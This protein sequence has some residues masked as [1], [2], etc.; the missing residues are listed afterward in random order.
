VKL[1]DLR[2]RKDPNLQQSGRT[3]SVD[4]AP[5]IISPSSCCS[6]CTLARMTS[7]RLQVRAN[8][9]VDVA[10]REEMGVGWD[11]RELPRPTEWGCRFR[12]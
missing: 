10:D 1:H 6:S 7:R 11:S 5:L 9:P 12:L 3:L 2:V 4:Y 8:F